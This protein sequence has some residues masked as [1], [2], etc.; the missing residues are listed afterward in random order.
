MELSSVQTGAPLEEEYIDGVQPSGLAW[1]PPET[2]SPSTP[3]GPVV[4]GA[5]GCDRTRRGSRPGCPRSAFRTR[6]HTPPTRECVL[7]P[8]DDERR[9]RRFGG[10][11]G[12]PLSGSA[13]QLRRGRQ[14]IVWPIP[15]KGLARRIHR[16]VACR[17]SSSGGS[18]TLWC[19]W[20]MR[21]S[22]GGCSRAAGSRI[23][24]ECRAALP[25]LE[26]GGA[27]RC[28]W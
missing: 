1:T 15:D 19:R 12:R 22:S 6:P 2:C 21:P 24:D 5:A 23:L 18:K 4:R 3:F 25:Q 8:P 26:Q 27:G 28:R 11:P 13:K 14:P 7:L 10:A 17:R 9:R 20:R 16:I